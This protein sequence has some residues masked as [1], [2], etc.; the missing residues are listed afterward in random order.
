MTILTPMN[1]WICNHKIP[2]DTA[3]TLRDESAG[4]GALV[5]PSWWQN[6]DGLIVAGQTVDTRLDE[7]EA[8]LGVLV[9]AVALE[10]LADGD[11]LGPVS[12]PPS[13]ISRFEWE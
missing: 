1:P 13:L 3:S 5:P 2:P 4:S 6:A 8:E 9:F 12:A 11:G 7:N 10:M